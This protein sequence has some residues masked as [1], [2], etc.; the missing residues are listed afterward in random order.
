MK[1][2]ELWQDDVYLFNHGQ[3]QKAYLSF[4]C[5]YLK[6]LMAHRFLVWA[7]NAK[8]VSVV[9]DFNGWQKEKNPMKKLDGGVWV[10]TIEDLNDGDLYKYLITS[11]D[12]QELYKA[13]PFAFYSQQRPD[14][15]SRVWS[16]EGYK[17]HDKAF[18]DGRHKKTGVNNPISIY[19]LHLGSWKQGENGEFLNYRQIADILAPYVKNMGFTHIELM[20]VTEYPLDDSWGYQVTGYYSITSRFGTPQDFMYFV[21]TLHKAGI[22][23]LL[24]WVPAHFP[25]D[26][27]GLRRFDGTPLYEYANP[28]QG[29]QPQWGTMLFNYSRPEVTSFLVSNAMFFID[30]YHIDGLRIDA[31]SAM[32]YLNFGKSDG[33]YVP[34]K[35]GGIISYDA[36]DFLR[37]VNETVMKNYTG[38]MMIAEES[39]AFPLVTKPPY[40]G[41]LGF[42][43]KWDMGFMNDT[44]CYMEADS[45]FRKDMHNNITFSMHYA[46]AENY[47]LSF[48][49]DE[50]VHG[51]RSM[52]DKMFGEYADKFSSLRAF[53]GYMFSHTGKKLLFMGD[54]FGQFLEWNHKKELEWFLLEYDSHKGLSNYVKTLNT[55]YKG[56][57]ALYEVEDGWDGF[58]WLNASDNQNSIVAYMRKSKYKKNTTMQ[59]V[60]SV[61]NFT[62]VL[63]EKYRVAMSQ[64]G[65][66]KEIL[67]SDSTE[68]GGAGISN[69]RAIK[70]VKKACE[71]KKFSATIM[72]PPLTTLYFE[73]TPDSTIKESSKE[74]KNNIRRK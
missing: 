46:F 14:T 2:A 36:V 71:G 50:V 5:H 12:N 30:C 60:L 28:L 3:A 54:E 4:G 43:Y 67:N 24:D 7:P 26:A 53:Y 72:V 57:K 68:F 10:T 42:S 29:E 1:T 47:V 56:N 21:D 13:D 40:D 61:T 23:V 20:P 51:K 22:G 66:L 19:E 69:K 15:A 32:L 41:G 35:D 62:P 8:A 74:Q 18:V 11:K 38:I 39:T 16:I 52:I 49:H 33:H 31:V 58:E 9:G 25:R 44:L 70:T 37:R 17:W 65:T 45:F 55:F 48:S 34:N 27:H 6:E 63:R 64:L 59:Y 73:F